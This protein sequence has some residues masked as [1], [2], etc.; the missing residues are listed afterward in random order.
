MDAV[1]PTVFARCGFA[2]LFEHFRQMAM[3]AESGV[4]CYFR[5]AQVCFLKKATRGVESLLED[6]LSRTDADYL[7]EHALEVGYGHSAF[8]CEVFHGKLLLQILGDFLYYR[9]EFLLPY[10]ACMFRNASAI[11]AQSADDGAIAFAQRID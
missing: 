10:G 3:V 7:H 9:I 1:E 6:V 11:C 4:E 5:Y 2:F 8:L